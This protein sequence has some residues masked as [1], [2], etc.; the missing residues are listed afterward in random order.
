[1]FKAIALVLSFALAGMG[2][3]AV[4]H[5]DLTSDLPEGAIQV[6]AT[7]QDNADINMYDSSNLFLGAHTSFSVDVYSNNDQE[8]IN[9]N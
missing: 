1:M 5:S 6:P 7:I 2:G 9:E 4:S 8:I 3:V